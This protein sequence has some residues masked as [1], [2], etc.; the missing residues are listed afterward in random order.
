M[1]SE[2]PQAYK[3]YQRKRL[4]FSFSSWLFVDLEEPPAE[5]PTYKVVISDYYNTITNT[6]KR[7]YFLASL[8]RAELQ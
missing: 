3:E 1:I 7:M 8:K 5:I 4:I 6:N 2:L